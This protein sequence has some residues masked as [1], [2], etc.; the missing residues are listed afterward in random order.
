MGD[1]PD[2]DPG[3]ST[4]VMRGIWC[5]ARRVHRL[6]E[7]ES[8]LAM[9]CARTGLIPTRAAHAIQRAAAKVAVD[10]AEVLEEGWAAG[11]PL[12]PLLEDLKQ[13]LEPEEAEFLHYGA[14][15]QDILDTATMLQVR[16]ALLVLRGMLFV[17]AGGLV[18]IIERHPHDFVMGRTLLQ[19]AVPIRFAWRVAQWL[20]PVLELLDD[21]TATAA[22]LPVQLGGPAGDL[23]SFGKAAATIVNAFAQ[24]LTLSTPPTTWHADRRPVL[25]PASLAEQIAR[26]AATIAADLLILSQSEIGEVRLPEGRSSSMPHKANAISAIRALAA[27]RACHGVMTVL[28]GAHPHELE[29]AAGSWHA[30]WFAVPLVFQTASAA[31]ESTSE[32]VAKLVFDRARAEANLGTAPLPSPAQADEAVSTAVAKYRALAARFGP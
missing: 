29:R 21:V 19:P 28:T 18:A 8:A 15:S 11:T 6:F 17:L 23:S 16:E 3:F 22:R 12:L 25:M 31:L 20:S 27:A 9:A 4:A 30:E 24:E 1:L 5:T 7:V 10:P 14:T 2:F 26:H 13:R 32:A